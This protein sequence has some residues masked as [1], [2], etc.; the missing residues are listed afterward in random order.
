MNY[1]IRS[2]AFIT[3]TY[4]NSYN[5]YFNPSRSPLFVT[6]I[7]SSTSKKRVK[8]SRAALYSKSATLRG[9]QFAHPWFNHHRL[10]QAKRKVLES[11]RNGC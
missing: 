2:A 9:P 1:Q 8:R 5:I 4:K 3:L 6:L 10:V 7:L 11:S